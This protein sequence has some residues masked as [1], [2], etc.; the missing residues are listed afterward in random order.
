MQT[1]GAGSETNSPVSA[2]DIQELQE[3]KVNKAL[4]I[5][6]REL[7]NLIDDN[8]LTPGSLYRINDYETIVNSANSAYY[9]SANHPFDI[10]VIALSENTL[11]ENAT[12][13]Q[14][15]GDTYFT[16]QHLETWE[17]KY[18]F[19]NDS[20]TFDWANSDGKGVIYYMKDEYG[21]ECPYDF[22]NI[23]FK[24]SKSDAPLISNNTYY[25]TF[26]QVKLVNTNLTI[27]S[28][29]DLSLSGTVFNNKILPYKQ[30]I[31]NNSYRY[32]LGTM[33]LASR[34]VN[35]NTRYSIF[36]NIIHTQCNEI[37]LIN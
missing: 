15:I 26:S 16:N 30:V 32:K 11:S 31:S 14:R 7:A 35:N 4:P 6:Y 29:I 5:S 3:N 24:S 9:V 12:A 18:R 25:Y 36:D 37:Y 17:L 19:S 2:T 33:I 28:S 22:K 10:I 8:G 23:K 21:N 20:N 1:I 27:D 34:G 13:I